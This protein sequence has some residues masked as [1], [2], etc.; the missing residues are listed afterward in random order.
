M[1]IVYIAHP[2]SGDVEG[3]VKRVKQI[4]RE[5]YSTHDNVHPIAPYLTC[6]EI[7][8]ENNKEERQKGIDMQ[9]Q[10]IRSGAVQEVWVYGSVLSQGVI[11][12]IE[13]A[14]LSATPVYLKEQFVNLDWIIEVLDHHK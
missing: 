6:L 13:A 11:G 3:N 7:L 2:I 4:M 10:L 12:E 1:K 14:M 9:L 5:I 8:N